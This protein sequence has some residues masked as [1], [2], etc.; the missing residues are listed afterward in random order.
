MAIYK[1]ISQVPFVIESKTARRVVSEAPVWWI[2]LCFIYP[3]PLLWAGLCQFESYCDVCAYYMYI[4]M[5]CV[6]LRFS[7]I[8]V[9]LYSALISKHHVVRDF[10]VSCL[11]GRVV[12]APAAHCYENWFQRLWVQTRAGAAVYIWRFLNLR[13]SYTYLHQLFAFSPGS[14]RSCPN[15]WDYPCGIT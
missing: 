12:S 11:D 5:Q 2:S 7:Q 6:S 8:V 15:F 9:K 14:L 13:E 1:V 3:I 10:C 4:S